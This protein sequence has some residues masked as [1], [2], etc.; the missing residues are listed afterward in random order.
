MKHTERILMKTTANTNTTDGVHIC[1]NIHP[2][3]SLVLNDE[4]VKKKQ[5]Y[6]F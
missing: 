2:G 1:T 6:M 3:S 4:W 5:T